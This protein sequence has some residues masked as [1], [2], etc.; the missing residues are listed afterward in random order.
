MSNNRLPSLN[1]LKAF[2]VV[3]RLG[4]INQAA[5]ELYLTHGAISRQISILEEQLA[6]ALL[7]KQGRGIKL[8][9]AGL[10]L[11]AMVSDSF[12]KLRLACQTIRQQAQI[13]PII[14]TCSGSLLAR[15]LIPRLPQLKD[16]LPALNLQIAVSNSDTLTEHQ[17]LQLTLSFLT[18]PYPAHQHIY[19]L[20]V[21]RLGVVLSPHLPYAKSLIASTP[22]SLLNYPVLH[23][24][25]RPQAWQQWLSAHKLQTNQLQLGQ[26]FEHLYYLLEAAIAGVG[27]AIA[28]QLLVN[29][30]LESGQLIAPWGF[31]E[32]ETYLALAVPNKS[33]SALLPSFIE[34]L[35]S[36]ARTH[37]V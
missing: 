28:P 6:V 12:E 14:L 27:I 36:N 11:A 30:E 33:Q 7:A 13:A 25:S 16:D 2:E 4:S 34:W 23:T 19:P 17:S 29:K 8:T 35:Q 3:A 5:Q 32:T 31:I 10:Q 22:Q 18:P 26:N 1:A 37:D 21:E 24:T 15:W 20:V 9:P